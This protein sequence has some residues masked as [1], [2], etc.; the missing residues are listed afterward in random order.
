MG[1]LNVQ[2]SLSTPLLTWEHCRGLGV[3]P[4]NFPNQITA[5]R[6]NA[7]RVREAKGSKPKGATPYRAQTSGAPTPPP[8][9]SPTLTF[10]ST[11]SPSSTEEYFLNESPNVL[12]KKVDLRDAL[13]KAMEGPPMQIH[14]RENAQPLAIHTP[15]L[16]TLAFRDAEK[17]ELDSMVAQGVI[18]PGRRRPVP[19]V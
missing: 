7:S 18:I 8:V 19:L 10:H 9:A 15:R 1:W 6:S 2:R 17:A 4:R 3:V 5:V 14:L 13:L 16:I 12:V 11:P